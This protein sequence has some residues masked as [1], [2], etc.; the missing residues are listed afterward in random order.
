MAKNIILLSDG[1]GNSAAKLFKTN[2]WRLYQ[3]LDLSGPDHPLKPGGREQIAFYDDGV[4]TSSFK[5]LAVLGGAFGWGLKRNVIHLYSFLCWNYEAG[6]RIYGFGFSRGAFTIRVLTGLIQSQGLIRTGSKRELLRLALSA[7]RAYRAE[8]YEARIANAA[9][10][11]R[12]GV[13]QAKN[14]AMRLRPYETRATAVKP[15]I[16]FL[17]LWDT[18]DAYGLPIDELTRAWSF[19]FPLSMRT[20]DISPNVA[21]ACHA[22]AVDDERNTFHP[23]LWNEENMSGQNPAAKRVE[24]ERVTQVLFSGM[25]SNVGGGYPDDGLA[26]VSLYWMMREAARAGLIFKDGEIDKVKAEKNVCGRMYDSRHGFGGTYRYLPRKFA[27]LA[28]D[29]DDPSNRVVIK[30][31]KVHESVIER[32]R[33]GVDGYAPIVL[34]PSY[35]VVTENGDILDLPAANAAPP[36]IEDRIQAESRSRTQEKI[37]NLV[38]RKRVVYF[39][40]IAVAL[41]LLAFPLLR[42]AKLACDFPLCGVSWLVRA[43]GAVLPAMANPWLDAF[44]SHPG[45]FLAWTF[46]LALLIRRGSKLRDRMQDE[47]RS[48]WRTLATTPRRSNDVD[49]LPDDFIY[50]LRTSPAYQRCWKITK[51]RILPFIAGALTVWL[52]FAGMTQAIF[53]LK[54]SLG[55]VCE[56]TRPEFLKTT[57]EEGAFPNDEV[58]WPTK[59]YAHAGKR[60]QIKIKIKDI[61]IWKD[62]GIATGIGGFGADKMTPLMYPALPL[63][64]KTTEPWFRPIARIGAI[65][66]DEYPLNPTD[67]SIPGEGDD[68]LVAE[69]TARRDGEIFLFVNDAILPVP[70]AWQYF[71]R[72]NHGA[73]TVAIRPVTECADKCRSSEK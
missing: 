66:N 54:S 42:P 48:L 67:R 69:I 25:H 34:P 40:A 15:P 9:R 8:R 23:V 19:F 30:R 72:N 10:A 20:R 16:D 36:F 12:Y 43:A 11:V 37:W 64:R 13:V 53:A 5:P 35:A 59:F 39:T 57:L 38:W 3:A 7:F 46:L 63:R 24:D 29:T 18:V 32:I 31:L 62:N 65:G 33:R 50:R 14:A 41:V 56:G 73:A 55:F 68:L 17:G 26:N 27:S 21:R 47:M 52:L 2:V 58:C 49:P 60:Y 1:T 44:A 28:N 70:N 6:D 45:A 61:N 51:E 71:Y 4:G 22:V